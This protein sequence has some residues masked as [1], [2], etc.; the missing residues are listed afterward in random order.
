MPAHLTISELA[1]RSGAAPSA[2]R[3]YEDLGLITAERTTGN[4]RRYARYMLRRVAFIKAGRRL[5]L[6]LGEVKV[7]LERLPSG[8]A[9][10]RTEWRR[11]AQLWQARIHDRIAELERLSETLG[12][13]IGCGCLSLKTCA[14]Y[15]PDDE[16]G[17]HGPGAR[18]LLEDDGAP[19]PARSS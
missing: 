4:Q 7:A 8:K 12:S 11:A 9:P 10:T 5:G 14:L 3:Y 18:W 17:T 19:E 6:S 15:N 16:A 1:A 2:L 13:C